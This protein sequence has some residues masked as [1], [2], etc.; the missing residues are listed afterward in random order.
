MRLVFEVLYVSLLGYFAVRFAKETRRRFQLY[1]SW[2]KI[3]IEI[4]SKAEKDQRNRK[5]PEWLR[6]LSA[7]FDLFTLF[8]LIAF[9]L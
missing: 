9:A 7:I 8:E 2:Y 3:E 6:R 1:M 4:L 5:R